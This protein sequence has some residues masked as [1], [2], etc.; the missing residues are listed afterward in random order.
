MSAI[1][2]LSASSTLALPSAAQN[3]T[4][5][6]RAGA[7]EGTKNHKPHTTKVWSRFPDH[8][9][10]IFAPQPSRDDE[11][12]LWPRIASKFRFVMLKEIAPMIKHTAFCKTACGRQMKNHYH[13]V[14]RFPQMSGRNRSV[15]TVCVKFQGYLT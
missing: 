7:S 13:C 12:Y 11:S 5:L 14:Q 2:C 10:P 9:T 15:V 4:D 6:C 8:Y 1:H 3:L